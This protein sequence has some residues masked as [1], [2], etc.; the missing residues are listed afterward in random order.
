MSAKRHIGEHVESGDNAEDYDHGEILDIDTTEVSSVLGDV[1]ALWVPRSIL[2][3]F[4]EGGTVP[5]H[6]FSVSFDGVLSPVQWGVLQ[7]LDGLMLIQEDADDLW[8]LHSP[9]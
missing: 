6:H 8:T 4:S 2:R 7:T 9:V 3:Q 5:D 1:R